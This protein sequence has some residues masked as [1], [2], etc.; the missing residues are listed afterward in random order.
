MTPSGW[1]DDARNREVGH[2]EMQLSVWRYLKRKKLE[3][4]ELKGDVFAPVGVFLEYPFEHNGRVIAFADICSV[5]RAAKPDYNNNYRFAYTAYEIRPR[6]QSAGAILRQCSSL[7]VV[8]ESRPSGTTKP[9]VSVIPVVPR[10]D[11]GLPL[12]EEM[13][14]DYGPV[15]TWDDPLPL[16]G[17]E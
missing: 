9:F 13:F 12:L 16:P 14:S 15:W 17:R 5:W 7:R 2:D 8:I 4:I 6:I 1:H 3:S 11:P 10:T